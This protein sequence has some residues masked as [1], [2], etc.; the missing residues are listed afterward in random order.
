MEP[1]NKNFKA[2]LKFVSLDLLF[3]ST[4]WIPIVLIAYFFLDS[5][6]AIMVACFA[7]L[8][9]IRFF[10]GR[11]IQQKAI[12]GYIDQKEPLSTISFERLRTLQPLFNTRPF[13]R[14]RNHAG[15]GIWTFSSAVLIAKLKPA[16]NDAECFQ[17]ADKIDALLM[18]RGHAK[19][20]QNNITFVLIVALLAFMA[21]LK[22]PE[23]RVMAFI[24]LLVLVLTA[25]LVS[26]LLSAL[27]LMQFLDEVKKTNSSAQSESRI[28]SN[29][30]F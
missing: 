14:G 3:L 25:L 20:W 9:P 11:L 21:S 15:K 26:E 5:N 13:L 17:T 22:M 18:T 24:G 10:I 1:K 4:A 16:L 7:L 30:L 29:P 27:N 8:I 6:R 12:L 2:F 23:Y 28:S 19:W